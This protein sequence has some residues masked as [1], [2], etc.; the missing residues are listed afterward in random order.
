MSSGVGTDTKERVMTNDYQEALRV[1]GLDHQASREDIEQAYLEQVKRWHPDRFMNDERRRREA[2]QRLKGVNNAYVCLEDF[3]PTQEGTASPQ[4]KVEPEK[5]KPSRGGSFKKNVVPARQSQTESSW[6][7]WKV[8]QK[9]PKVEREMLRPE[10][11]WMAQVLWWRVLGLG[12]AIVLLAATAMIT[13]K[14]VVPQLIALRGYAMK[15]WIALLKAVGTILAGAAALACFCWLAV[16]A[17][18]V[19]PA[20]R[21]Q[22]RRAQSSKGR[23]ISTVRQSKKA[24]VRSWGAELPHIHTESSVTSGLVTESEQ[25][26]RRLRHGG[27][28]S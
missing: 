18:P 24:D 27:R 4:P 25:P 13:W 14:W 10:V 26:A 15:D 20:T 9:R 21:P 16:D 8:N 23:D 12:V 2:E 1:L 19:K 22:R 5:A 17:D 6:Y 11:H 28:N 3:Q 7:E